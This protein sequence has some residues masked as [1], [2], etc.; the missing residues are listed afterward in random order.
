MSAWTS[1][2]AT[3]S[4]VTFIA[5]DRSYVAPKSA[6]R[7]VAVDPK[8]TGLVKVEFENWFSDINTWGPLYLDFNTVTS[9][10]ESTAA[11]LASA[12]NGLVY[13]SAPDN[14]GVAAAGVTAVESGT[15]DFH[16]T[17]LTVSN[18][19][20]GAIAAA[21]NEATG[22][23]VYTLPAGNIQVVGAFMS[24]ALTNSDGNIDADTPDVGVGTT[25]G[26]GAQ[27]LLSGVGAAAE[28]IITGTTAADVTGTATV[29]SVADIALQIAPA[30]DHT[31]YLNVADGW[32]GA[33]TGVIA[34]GTI[35]M[36]WRYVG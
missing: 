25:V 33:E 5:S 12:I 26:S 20:L 16:K 30:G 34:N 24:I 19:D 6:I 7:K 13:E 11:G 2:T 21:A 31:V 4:E 35:T 8:N 3:K 29:T 10:S 32:A 15:N 23:L 22:A 9:P 1:V 27:A 17:V 28:N 18:L 36:V 14:A